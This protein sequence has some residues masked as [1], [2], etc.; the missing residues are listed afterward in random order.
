MQTVSLS[1]GLTTAPR[2]QITLKKSILSLRSAGFTETIHVFAEPNSPK[3]N[4]QGIVW[5][6]AETEL[7]CFFNWKRGAEWLFNNAP[8]EYILMVQDDVKYKKETR[9]VLEQ[10]LEDVLKKPLGFI[11]LYLARHDGEIAHKKHGWNQHDLPCAWGALTYLFNRGSLWA[12]MNHPKYLNHDVS[13]FLDCVVCGAMHNMGR[14]MW[15]HTP[16]LATHTGIHST[17]GHFPME[18]HKGYKF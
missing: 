16:S 4:G 18:E 10:H 15:Y 11:T 14:T 8:E 6:E 1:I 9:V 12:L 2:K 13:K 5:H 7:G 3:Y 17:V